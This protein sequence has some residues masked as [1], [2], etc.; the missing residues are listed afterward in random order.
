[1]YRL[2]SSSLDARKKKLI[3]LL[4]FLAMFAVASLPAFA[5]REQHGAPATHAAPAQ[6][7]APAQHG[8]H[9]VG[10][11]YIPNRGPVATHAPARSAPH[12]QAPAPA[13]H[14]SFRDAEGH[15]EAPHVHAE[16]DRWI[17]HQGHDAGYHLD[18]PWEHGHFSGGIGPRHVWR[19]GGGS[20]E[21]FGVGGFFF[22]IAGP[23]IGF[24]NGWLWDND[25]IVIY[26]DPDDPGYYLAYNVRLG[27]Y[28]HVLYLGA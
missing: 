20:P 8:E 16:N 25:D 26:D 21:R 22:S 17:G 4:G 5:Q 10:G 2:N 3:A 15:P 7:S 28:V 12:N 11:G 6:H 19:L 1:M 13:E 23:D 18:H 9:G 24:A 27:T 14:R